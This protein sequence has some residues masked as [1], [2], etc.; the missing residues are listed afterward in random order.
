MLLCCCR[1]VR[2]DK[3]KQQKGER[4]RPSGGA[5]LRLEPDGRWDRSIC[6]GVDL[7]NQIPAWLALPRENL[8]QIALGHANTTSKGVLADPKAVDMIAKVLHA[9]WFAQ[10]KP[11]RKQKGLHTASVSK[12][13]NVAAFAS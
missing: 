4:A 5:F 13:S 2:T 10:S 12:R 7:L 9:L 8:A 3:L 6:G 11:R 1:G